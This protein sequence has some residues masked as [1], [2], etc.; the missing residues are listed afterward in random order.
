MG[1][2]QC[3]GE[4]DADVNRRDR[5]AGHFY[6]H[7]EDKL[8][9]LRMLTRELRVGLKEEDRWYVSESESEEDKEEEEQVEEGEE[10]GEEEEEEEEEEG[11]EEEEEAE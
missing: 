2:D 5:D 10:E 9:R 6:E 8:E 4:K 7:D 1:N 11:E 3:F